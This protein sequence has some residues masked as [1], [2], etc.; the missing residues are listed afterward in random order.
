[1]P[2]SKTNK[3][4]KERLQHPPYQDFLGCSF[5]EAA[6]I[7]NPQVD[8]NS[9]KP[10]A[11]GGAKITFPM[12]FHA[13]LE[14]L[15]AAGETDAVRWQPHGRAFK[16]TNRVEFEKEVLP[17]F[18]FDYN[19]RYASFQRQLNI[20]SFMRLS[21]GPDAGAYYHSL[22]LRSRPD[23]CS[24]MTRKKSE[25]NGVRKMIDASTEP[26]LSQFK[27]MPECPITSSN[28]SLITSIAMN[29]AVVSATVSASRVNASESSFS[30]ET[31][32]PSTAATSEVLPN[33]GIEG[34]I[35]PR[36][37]FN[38]AQILGYQGCPIVPE[39]FGSSFFDKAISSSA[40][41][42][43]KRLK[44][45][46]DPDDSKP[47]ANRGP[48]SNDGSSDTA[49]AAAISAFSDLFSSEAVAA[50]QH[51]TSLLPNGYLLPLDPNS[52]N[53]DTM[54]D[55]ASLARFLQDFDVELSSDDE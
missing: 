44:L 12:R 10:R 24:L 17:K 19:C 11:R 21:H 49:A 36:S 31:T 39:F 48:F 16:V 52:R 32:S 55:D 45:E 15:S 34:S 8:G 28:D 14:A 22:F 6:Q 41:T 13:L 54:E 30:F 40:P 26:D 42:N 2:S 7:L 9:D 18:G 53:G 46:A 20:Y 38:V 29:H 3:N 23:L 37:T 4:Q 50:T 25:T 33:S 5:D 51:G 43:N 27:S 1:M 47:A 35:A